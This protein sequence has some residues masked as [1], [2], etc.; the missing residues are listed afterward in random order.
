M[1]DIDKGYG[2]EE[3]TKQ[4]EDWQIPCQ[5]KF[6]VGHIENGCSQCLH[7]GVAPGYGRL[8]GWAFPSEKQKAEQGYI[9]PGFNLM[10]AAGAMGGRKSDWFFPGI[11]IDDDVQ[12]T[13]NEKSK[14]N[15]K[16]G[17]HI[18]ILE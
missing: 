2:D 15:Y 8:A 16:K 12:K 14:Q 17:D 3:T 5:T 10:I 13:A 4:C 11:A 1:V 18:Y 6:K 7:Q 9:F